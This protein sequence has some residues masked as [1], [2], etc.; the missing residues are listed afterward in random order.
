MNSIVGMYVVLLV[1][2]LCGVAWTYWYRH[3]QQ[4][5]RS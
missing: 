5:H 4:R 2:G 1:I 3:Q